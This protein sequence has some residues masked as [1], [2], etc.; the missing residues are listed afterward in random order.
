MTGYI[1]YL[2]INGP[3]DWSCQDIIRAVTKVIIRM[4]LE[5]GVSVYKDEEVDFCYVVDPQRF[6]GLINETW[7]QVFTCRRRFGHEKYPNRITVTS[8]G[9][10]G[11]HGKIQIEDGRCILD[12][13][14]IEEKKREIKEVTGDT[15][16]VDV[17]LVACPMVR[18]NG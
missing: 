15:L 12:R 9:R 10:G 3:S 4:L 8:D 7:W 14:P 16:E 17:S 2:H 11:T 18:K 13:R 5:D 1:S 6:V